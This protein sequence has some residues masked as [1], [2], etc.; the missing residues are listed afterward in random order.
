MNSGDDAVQE[1]EQQMTQLVQKVLI[2]TVEHLLGN[3]SNKSFKGIKSKANTAK[4]TKNLK[5]VSCFDGTLIT[6]QQ[7]KS[8]QHQECMYVICWERKL[9]KNNPIRMHTTIP[10]EERCIYK[11]N[12]KNSKI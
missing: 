10:N 12:I 8:E 9:M 4:E 11:R 2:D 1:K 6:S 5:S 7:S 3:R